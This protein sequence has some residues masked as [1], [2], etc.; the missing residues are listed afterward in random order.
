MIRRRTLL[1][2]A[3]L[4]GVGLGVGG[5]AGASEV[6]RHELNH[7]SADERAAADVDEWQH[8]A[9]DYGQTYRVTAPATLM[10]ALTVD[11]QG[12]QL[13]IDRQPDKTAQRQLRQASA[14]LATFTALTAGNLG[15][16]IEARRWWRTARRVADQAGDPYTVLWV[17]GREVA[18]AGYEHR[19]VSDI[20]QL[21]DEAE[22]R[23]DAA[24]PE[25]QPEL[26]AGKA[27]TLALAGRPVDAEQ[28]L[29]QVR[30]CFGK[31]TPAS[32]RDSTFDWGEENLR[33]T[34]SFVYSHLGDFA[35][36]DQ[37]QNAA[38]RL[39]PDTAVRGPAKIELLRALCLTRSGDLTHGTRHA[40]TIITDLPVAHHV[41]PVADLGQ[42]VLNAIPAHERRQSWAQ[43]Y[44][45]CVESSFLPGQPTQ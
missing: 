13:A 12:L 34:E 42:K 31:L 16:L 37:A 44:R 28:A 36:A 10:Q 1:L 6:V 33:Y 18:R 8:I 39:Y 38:L 25:A 19:P 21:A 11:L 30:E 27:Q 4:G 26:L 40:Q 2:K 15:K 7:V 22:A 45:E 20:L 23:L 29:C 41:R 32:R 5:T 35:K 9:W 3:T 14:L 17:R 43:E 24:P